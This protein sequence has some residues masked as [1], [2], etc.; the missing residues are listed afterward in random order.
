MYVCMYVS[1]SL[2]D[3]WIDVNI[4]SYVSGQVNRKYDL[5]KDKYRNVAKQMQHKVHSANFYYLFN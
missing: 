1:Y 5:P 3:K 4:K 2:K